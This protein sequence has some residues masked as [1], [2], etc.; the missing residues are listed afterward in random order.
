MSISPNA[1]PGTLGASARISRAAK[2]AAEYASAA[3]IVVRGL[4]DP[5]DM[6]AASALLAEVWKFEGNQSHLDPGLLVAL[7]HADNY[8]GGAFQGERLVAVCVGFFHP[9][10]DRALHSH[11]AGVAPGLLGVGIGKA[12]KHHQRAW[13]LEHGAETM[14][15]TFDPLVARNAYF[16]LHRLGG[17]ATEYLPDF[18]GV[19]SDGLNRGHA[20]DRMMLVWDLRHEPAHSPV[21]QPEPESCAL[22][23]MNGEPR[24]DLG[25]VVTAQRCRVEIPSDIEGMRRDQPELAGRWRLALRDAL[26]VLMNDGWRVTDFA[27]RGYYCL[28]RTPARAHSQH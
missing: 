14:T 9:P 6:V 17:I 20:S 16:N 4:R 2:D 19:M 13:C 12:L 18:Y 27:R 3:G 24:L 26:A 11:I 15:W 10:L 5:K 23:N 8:V 1:S 22:H 21:E 25:A 28:E 7:A